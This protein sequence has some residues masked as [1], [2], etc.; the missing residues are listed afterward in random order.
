MA[1][2]KK[3]TEMGKPTG[4]KS[5]LTD[6]Q[7]AEAEGR[8]LKGESLRSLAL[9]YKI[10]PTSFR[11]HFK[12][13]ANRIEEMKT[14]IGQIVV[15]EQKMAN[16]P[17]VAQ[18]TVRDIA[19]ELIEISNQLAGAAK[20]G[21]RTAHRLSMIANVQAEQIDET[22][23]LDANA[24]VLQSVLAMTETANK[25]S[26]IGMG[27]LAANSKGVLL[28]AAAPKEESGLPKDPIEASKVYARLMKG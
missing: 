25:A 23:E 17:S 18:E 10:S 1:A 12:T 2:P 5:L 15:T 16:L 8:F 28:P 26:T 4:R 20:F 13:Y 11:E 14:V 22:A 9:E 6:K 24:K 21:A 7:W 27:L 19:S 3:K